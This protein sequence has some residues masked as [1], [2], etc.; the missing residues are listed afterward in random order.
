MPA[1]PATR[2]V[3]GVSGL[4][5]KPVVICPSNA[6]CATC[7]VYVDAAWTPKTGTTSELEDAMLD[8]A[9]GKQDNSRLACQ[10]FAGPQLEGL[11]V[12]MPAT[13]H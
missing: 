1:S 12:T 3:A 11:V 8:L 2:K 10:I 6:A 5:G 4:T 13:Q 9:D 7:H